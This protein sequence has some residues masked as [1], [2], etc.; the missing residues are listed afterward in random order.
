MDTCLWITMKVNGDCKVNSD[1]IVD[2]CEFFSETF[3]QINFYAYSNGH[4]PV[5]FWNFYDVFGQFWRKLKKSLP[6]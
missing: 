1:C 2:I 5:I 6:L 3:G 4:G